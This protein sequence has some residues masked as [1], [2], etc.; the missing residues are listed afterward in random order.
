MSRPKNTIKVM[1]TLRISEKKEEQSR[2]IF[3]AD[4]VVSRRQNDIEVRFES[5]LCLIT[6]QVFLITGIP[7]FRVQFLNFMS[8]E[9]YPLSIESEKANLVSIG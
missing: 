6:I 7:K 2:N 9:L 3:W 1:K 8:K 5:I 4:I